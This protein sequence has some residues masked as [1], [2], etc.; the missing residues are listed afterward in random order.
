MSHSLV[1][2]SKTIGYKF[3]SVIRKYSFNDLILYALSIG[4][5]KDPLNTRDFKFTY[6][7]D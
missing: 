7:R 3:P 1:D 4:F 6:E 5:N 2:I